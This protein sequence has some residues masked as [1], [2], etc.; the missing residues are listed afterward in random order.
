MAKLQADLDALLKDDA[1]RFNA[2][3]A[4]VMGTSATSAAGTTAG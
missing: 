1:A 2:R 3:V 4:Q